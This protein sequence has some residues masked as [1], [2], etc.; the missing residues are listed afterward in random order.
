MASIDSLIR[1]K[2]K[3]LVSTTVSTWTLILSSTKYT[4]SNKL[5]DYTTRLKKKW[6]NK[7]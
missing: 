6:K 5:T 2:N 4:E 7:K 3:L 1:N